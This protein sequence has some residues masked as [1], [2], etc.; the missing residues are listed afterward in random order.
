MTGSA[1]A[2]DQA[3]LN[4][5]FVPWPPRSLDR[6]EEASPERYPR[7]MF[8]RGGAPTP[9]PADAERQALFEQLA[10]RPE[11]VCPFL[12]LAEARADYESQ[13]T[14][15]HR[16][17]AFGDPE[18]VS[19]EQQRNV[20]LQR[21]YANCPRYLRGVLVIPT[22]E[23]EALRRPPQKVPPPPT[24]APAPP[25]APDSSG[26]R[27]RIAAVLVLLLLLGGGA[28]AWYFLAG[29]GAV[30]VAPT[31]TPEA[32][33]PAPSAT[34]QASAEA[35]FVGSVS[36]FEDLTLSPLVELTADGLR[37]TPS[38]LDSAAAVWYPTPLRV[39]N[40]FEVSYAFRIAEPIGDGGDGLAL[41]IQTDG[42]EV[43][44]GL[45][46]ELGYGGLTNSLAVEID[47]HFNH[48]PGLDDPNDNHIGVQSAGTAPISA[49]HRYSLG[50][51]TDI[52]DVSDGQTHTLQAI[53]Q[54]GTLEITLDDVEV[55]TVALQLDDLITLG[56]GGTAYV[57][58]TA[59]TGTSAQVQTIVS[60]DMTLH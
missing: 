4:G 39:I 38:A 45:G 53:Y 46:A 44:G 8:K 21:G 48:W 32:T 7:G 14:D 27:R 60:L 36:G 11:T 22:D 51:T 52:P 37:M 26:G 59:S 16:C 9:S 1:C 5:A 28:G 18:P 47:T 3:R 23:L 30:A 54:P 57:G 12:G 31:P 40:G 19:G 50:L 49:D 25:P 33:S 58:L 35:S 13:A 29:P 6:V 34:L 24:A 20:C 15:Q 17:Y 56:G 2:A 41:V 55:L 10:Q 43:V 42:P